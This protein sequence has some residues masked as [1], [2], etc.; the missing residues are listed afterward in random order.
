MIL[1]HDDPQLSWLGAISLERTESYTRPWRIPFEE[2][3]LFHPALVAVAS[4][5]AGIRLAFESSSRRV[6]GKIGLLE[7]NQ[8]L[9]LFVRGEFRESIEL[10]GRASFEFIG[11]DAESKLIEL[12]LPQAGD[13]ALEYLEIDDGSTITSKR[14]LRPKWITYG[15]S[16]S[17]CLQAASPSKTWPAIVAE[18]SGLNL[19]CL[20]FNGQCHLD[21]QVARTIRGLEADYI[22]ICAGINTY[23]APSLNE[24]TF[25]SSLVGFVQVIRERHPFVPIL[26][27]SPTHSSTR[28]L[29]PNSQGWT[30]P[31]YRIAVEET[32]NLLRDT[33]DR[34]IHYLDG[35]MLF[36]AAHAPLA[37]DGL[38]PN[39]EGYALMGTN[40]LL[41][42]AP[43]LFG[44]GASERA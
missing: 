10:A 40:F 18:A 26:L 8:K 42:A 5:Q 16:I 31:H 32:V 11:L 2:R 3:R 12:W 13:F 15:S 33:G 17:H 41:H 37:P 24:R 9:D 20:G 23:G 19:T 21:I 39:A 4:Q 1:A 30:L 25:G 35:R 7:D 38:H 27:I 43:L 29:S 34:N 22:S 6:A 14:D 36:D 44:I 28:E